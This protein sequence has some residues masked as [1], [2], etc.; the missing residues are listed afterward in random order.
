MAT[1]G[2]KLPT[3]F[4]ISK[5]LNPDG[6]V[7]SPAEILMQTNEV[8]QDFPVLEGNLPTGHKETIR[9][10]LPRAYWKRFNAGTPMSK[11]RTQQ[12]TDTIGMLEAVS[13][14]DK[15]LAALNGNSAA[16]R[17]SEDKPFIES[18]SQEL[19]RTIFYGNEL[20]NPEEFTGL[21][22]RYSD[23]SAE[24]GD[25]I[26]DAG[27]TTGNLTSLWLI[28][29]DS[30]TLNMRYPKGQSDTSSIESE[31]QGEQ[32]IT[33]A[34]GGRLTVLETTFKAKLGLSVKDWRYA[35]RIANIPVDALDDKGANVDLWNKLIEA[36]HK[37]PMLNKGTCRFYMNRTVKQYLD[38]QSFNK[39]NVRLGQQEVNGV[40]VPDF[41]SIPFRTCDSLINQEERVL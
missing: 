23:K 20:T 13:Q 9:T 2:S 28:C 17:A 7:A 12:A 39:E 31:D 24:I 21:S 25:N 30:D 19:A 18:L 37:L 10:G 27:G 36:M 22:A 11:S 16:W 6:T 15:D 5:R 34:N 14:V 3:L 29:W 35:V 8:L 4:D 38:L 33:D 1:L 26:I 32:R 40:M 41:R